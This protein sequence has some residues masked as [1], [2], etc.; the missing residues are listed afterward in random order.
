[1]EQSAAGRCTGSLIERVPLGLEDDL[2]REHW[3]VLVTD[4][5]SQLVAFAS[6]GLDYVFGQASERTGRLDV[7]IL[8]IRQF[9]TLFIGAIS[10]PS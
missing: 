6:V 10:S 3:S 9:Q 1:L 8:N 7:R 4:F 2:H 5:D